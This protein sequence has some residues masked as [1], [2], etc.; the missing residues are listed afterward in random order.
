[1]LFIR[2]SRDFPDCL[3]LE[4]D[5]NSIADIFR[6]VGVLLELKGENAFK[7]RAYQSGA[8]ALESLEEELSVLIA[9]DRLTDVK[10]I[11]KALADKIYILHGEG[12]LPFYEELRA[13]VPDGLINML[14]IAG[15]GAKKI[16]AL[17]EALG[18]DSIEKLEKACR[19]GRVASIAGFGAKSEEKILIGIRNREGISG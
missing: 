5:K 10:G 3:V 6:D 18:V 2:G 8:R 4:M 19:E 1:M 11:G 13:S 17:Y 14:E 16:R 15:L 9:E 12:V 7:I